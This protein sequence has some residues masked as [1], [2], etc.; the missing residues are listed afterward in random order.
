MRRLDLDA[1]RD[2]AREEGRSEGERLA[3]ET[4]RDRCRAIMTGPHSE[5]R[6]RQARYLALHTDLDVVECDAIL[7]AAPVDAAVS[8][9]VQ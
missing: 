4:E 1:I 3:R 5:L 6:E 9:R 7:R 8:D 2:D